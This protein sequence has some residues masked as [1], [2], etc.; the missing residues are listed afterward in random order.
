VQVRDEFLSVASHELK[1]PLTSLL[2]ATHAVLRITRQDTLP[3]PEYL[4]RRVKMVEDQSKRLAHLVNNLLDISRITAGRLQLEPQEL[5]LAALTRQVVE[6]FQEELDQAGC[7]VTLEAETPVQGYWDRARIEQVVTNL[8]TNAMKY[9]YGQPIGITVTGEGP[10]A[11]LSVCDQGIGI[12]PEQQERIFG[13]FER[14]V[15]PGKYGGMGLGLYIVRQI[16]EAHGG[17]IAVNSEPGQGACF[18]VAVPRAP[19]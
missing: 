17:S 13:R 11:R 12:A 18:T 3:T 10:M 7:P 1:T 2:L 15:A 5:D 16:V 4:T 19:D 9:G 14:A 8:L 6:Q